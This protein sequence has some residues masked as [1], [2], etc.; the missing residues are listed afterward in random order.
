MTIFLILG[1]VAAFY[2]LWLLFRLAA[3]GL[4]IYAGIS[5]GLFMHASGY[6]YV[7][8]I[9]SGL[10]TGTALLLVARLLIAFSPLLGWPTLCL[11][12]VPAAFAGYQT[13]AGLAGQAID[14]GIWLSALSW[15]GALVAASGAWNGLPGEAAAEPASRPHPQAQTEIASEAR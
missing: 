1:A 13:A 2:L 9:M 14:P 3:L 7:A 6:G 11:F 8:S 12:I 4:P 10:A 5:L 15:I